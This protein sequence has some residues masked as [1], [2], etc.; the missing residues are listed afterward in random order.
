M[1]QRAHD[2]GHVLTAIEAVD[3]AAVDERAA[4]PGAAVGRAPTVPVGF[5]VGR[6]CG[7]TGTCAHPRG[8]ALERVTAAESARAGTVFP[9]PLAVLTARVGAMLTRVRRTT[10]VTH[11]RLR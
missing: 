2:V 6:R 7:L 4:T 8:H 10:D 9:L 1:V 5:E 11:N 3:E